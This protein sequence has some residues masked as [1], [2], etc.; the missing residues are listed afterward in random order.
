[1]GHEERIRELKQRIMDDL[2][3]VGQVMKE[4]MQ[5]GG[6]VVL[7]CQPYAITKAKAL[8]EQEIDKV[9]TYIKQ[10]AK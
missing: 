8:V 2:D 1:M 7:M 5:E 6:H 3:A 4:A 10:Q 9:S